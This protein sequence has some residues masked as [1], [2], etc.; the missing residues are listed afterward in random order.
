MGADMPRTLVVTGHFAPG[1]GGV[2]RFTTEIVARMPAD[3]VVVAA[4]SP[5]C[6]S[7]AER[8]YPVHRYGRR[9]I[10]NPAL[11]ARL[12][13]LVREEQ[14]TAAW[15]TSGIPLGTMAPV[16][17]RAGVEHIVVST[18]GQETGWSSVPPTAA[19]MRQFVRSI[20]VLTYLGEFTRHRL[21]PGIPPNV[22]MQ[23]LTGGVDPQHFRPMPLAGAAIRDQLRIAD[24][25]VV[26][27]ASRLVP[28]KGQDVLLRAWPQLL[29]RHPDA[30]L[31]VVGDGPHGPHLAR[32]MTELGLR[33][34]VRFT[35]SV[36]DA[37]LP[38]VLNAGQIFALPCRTV[39]KGLQPEGLGL[40]IL[41]ASSVGLPVVV[42]RSGGAPDAVQDGRT[43][44][45]VEGTDEAA[46]VEALDTLLAH[47]AVARRMGSA[48]REW[49]AA[50][51]SWD[52][53]ADH[54]LSSFREPR[55]AAA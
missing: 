30:V 31:L 53:M 44:L 40:S 13:R 18:H 39:W 23:Q 51:W 22:E 20:D 35:G 26:V 43:G 48:G 37:T 55:A 47:S 24:R 36:D 25:P 10:N 15:L 45:L 33:D 16:L 17:R 41:E 11:P 8:P 19:I 52:V 1:R 34:H 54:L 6:P 3:Q 38:S 5:G 46:I 27:S 50:R 9:L 12:T 21:L 42:G 28:R 29:R 7:D 14:C 49:V 4:P 2:E 32:L